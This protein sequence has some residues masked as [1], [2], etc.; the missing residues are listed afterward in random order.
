[1]NRMIS[2]LDRYTLISNSDCHSPAKLGREANIFD[3]GFDYHSLRE[4]LQTPADS[5]GR[6]RFVATVEFFPEEGKYHGD[7]HRKCGINLEPLQTRELNGLCPVCGKALTVGVLNRVFELADRN[8]PVFP[9]S[10]PGVHS[11]IPLA[12]MVAELLGVGPVS[13]KVTAAYARLIKL[14]GSEFGLLLDAPME[15]LRSQ[16]LTLL[17]EAIERVRSGKVI[18]EPGSDGVYGVIR[19]FSEGERARLIGQ[20]TLFPQAGAAKA[21]VR[22]SKTPA[23]VQPA[24]AVAPGALQTAE[25]APTRQLNEAQQAAVISSAPVS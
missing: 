21:R 6:Q 16:G 3:T 2:A 25:P 4:A 8:E 7:G 22:S 23:P 1:M 18:R 5:A 17:A 13:K 11:L 19:V 20:Q 24:T 10:S 9:P 14:F 15:E 12:E